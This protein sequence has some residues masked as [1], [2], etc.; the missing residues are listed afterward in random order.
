[1]IIQDFFDAGYYINLD[2][3]LDRNDHITNL[4]S[5]MGLT[6]FVERIS[7]V[8]GSK[9]PDHIL[10]QHYCSQSHHKIFNIAKERNLKRFV[11][12]EDDFML[13][14]TDEYNGLDIIESGLEQ[15]NEIQDWDIVYFGGY[16][17]DK[18]IKKVNT[19]LLKVDTILALH[20]YGV[21]KSGLHKLLEH[22]P[23]VDCQLDGWIGDKMHINKYVIYPM[24]SY[25]IQTQSNLDAYYTT[26]PIDHW[27][28]CYITND[29]IIV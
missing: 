21:S 15:L 13:Y 25:Q 10:R 9:E 1:M 17:F 20:G 16:I 29:K 14:N 4:F 7:G 28:E 22:K 8:D 24:A 18:I 2:F 23:F 12:F 5:K 26:P 19:N 27:K 11:V 6:H 3:R